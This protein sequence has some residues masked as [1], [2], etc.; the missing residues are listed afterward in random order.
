MP[1]GRRTQALRGPGA[2]GFTPATSV[3]ASN[4]CLNCGTN[5]QLEYCPECGQREIDPDPTLKEFLHDLAEE[6]LRWDGKLLGT[7]RLLVTKPGALT[8]S[9]LEGKRVP[10]IAPLKLYLTCSVLYFFVSALAPTPSVKIGPRAGNAQVALINIVTSDTVKAIAE[11][12]S[13]ARHGN[14]IS[15]LWGQHFSQAMRNRAALDAS[16]RAAIPKATFALLPLFAALFAVFFR[17]R[18]RKYPQHLV[19]A[20]HIHAALFMALTLLL[21]ARVTSAPSIRLA[22][23]MIVGAGLGVYT[24]L[25]AHRVYG[26]SQAGVLTRL[27]GVAVTYLLSFGVVMAATFAIIVLA[28]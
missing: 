16:V 10:F 20:M 9:Y 5:I 25:A 18:R 1:E 28:N 11:L 15:R 13:M 2:G 6:M 3:A 4:P 17:D 22:V 26:G 21:L 7:L 19:F 8:V 24:L 23:E 14:L 27:L 12:D